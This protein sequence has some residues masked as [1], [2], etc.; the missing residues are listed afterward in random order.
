MPQL[1][2]IQRTKV[3][4]FWHQ[5]K[6]V[7]K[8]QR[9]YRRFFNTAHA[10]NPR[11]I[12]R[13]VDK[14]STVGTVCNV[15]KGRSGRRR[16]ARS[17][18]NVQAVREA[19]VRSPRKSIRRL[20]KESSMHRTSVHR[21]LTT[22]LQLFPYKIQSQSQL[23]DEQREKRLQFAR[24]FSEKLEAD[25][26]FLRKIHMTDEC[27]AHLTGKINKHN[28]RYWG[29]E[30]PGDELVDEI[31][32]TVLK[33]TV[34]VAIG[35]YGIIGPY[36]FEDDDGRTT[37]VN[38]VNYRQMIQDFYL[39]ELRQLS[40]RRGNDIKMRTQWF[41]QDG[42]PP[43]TAR[44]TRQFLRTQFPGRVIS[45]Y[46]DIEWPPYS[47]DLTPPDFFLWG[48]LK[49]RI[50]AN[51]KPRDIEQLKANIRRVIQN[52]PHETFPNVMNNVAVRLQAVI[53]RKGGY[54]DHV[55]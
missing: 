50:Y 46:E 7:V 2:I 54:I 43:H 36:F 18:E 29:T 33:V 30:N 49:D 17:E 16:T 15:N 32:R 38:Q 25:D 34:W 4:E 48:Y 5:T 24:W 41:Q 23:T 13:T 52:I 10:P 3:I 40:R 39:P 21:I 26:H 31:P 28:F 53:G 19:V 6:S 37:T 9:E 8:V 55:V 45:L 27:H 47:P 14:F 11:T 44:A 1:S 35:W 20:S 12:R 22:D 51:P 42:A